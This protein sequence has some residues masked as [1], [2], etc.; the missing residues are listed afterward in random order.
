MERHTLL[1]M[2]MAKETNRGKYAHI[3]KNV[4]LTPNR[5]IRELTRGNSHQKTRKEKEKN[6]VIVMEDAVTPINILQKITPALS[7]DMSAQTLVTKLTK[8]FC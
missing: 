3:I 8:C 2:V 6:F 7:Q 5:K 1:T 4:Q